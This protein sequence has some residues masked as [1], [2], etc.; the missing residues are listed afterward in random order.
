MFLEWWKAFSEVGGVI[1]LFLTFVF[2]A[3]ALITNN[4][5]NAV[6]DERL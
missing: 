3:G 5:I 2:G 4:R 6:Q 1:L